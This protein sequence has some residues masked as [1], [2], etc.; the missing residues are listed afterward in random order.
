[1]CQNMELHVF[2]RSLRIH[3]TKMLFLNGAEKTRGTVAGAFSAVTH[4]DSPRGA[5]GHFPGLAM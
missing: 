4:Q 3:G 1:M 5:A 2:S